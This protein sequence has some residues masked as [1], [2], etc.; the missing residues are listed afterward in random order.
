MGN[1]QRIRNNQPSNTV[2][3]TVNSQKKNVDSAWRDLNGGE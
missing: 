3:R 2:V 1:V